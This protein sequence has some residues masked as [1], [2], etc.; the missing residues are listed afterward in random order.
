LVWGEER[1]G[2]EGEDNLL[3]AKEGDLIINNMNP[4]AIFSINRAIIFLFF[5]F[6]FIFIFLVGVNI[7]VP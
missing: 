3:S 2:G 4:M 1:R 7:Q 5:I 6:I